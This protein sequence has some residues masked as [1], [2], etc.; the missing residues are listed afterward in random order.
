MF[1][2]QMV[3]EPPHSPPDLIAEHLGL[4]MLNTLDKRA[5]DL[6]AEKGSQ[7]WQYLV[8]VAPHEFRH[9]ASSTLPFFLCGGAVTRPEPRPK[10]LKEGGV[11]RALAERWSTPSEPRD[12]RLPNPPSLG[13]KARFTHAWFAP[14]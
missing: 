7:I 11:T 4:E 12:L 14:G 6:N 10:H 3:K 1:A 9:G 13:D 2:G 8:T 5:Q